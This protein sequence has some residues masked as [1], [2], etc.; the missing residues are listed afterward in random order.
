MIWALAALTVATASA[1]ADGPPLRREDQFKA[2]YVFNF[3]RFVEWPAA[4]SE[5][6]TVC[7]VGA[8][9]VYQALAAGIENKRA[10]ARR[11]AVQRLADTSHAGSCH[12]LY[13]EASMAAAYTPCDGEAMLTISDAKGFAQHGGMIELFSE[14][15]RLRFRIN[16]HNA[17]Q[18]GLRISSDLL[19]LAAAVERGL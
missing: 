17:H 19:K 5:P 14:N 3:I 9:G 11:L 1:R 10:G 13:I 16:V 8:E 7:F 18:T 4:A 15:H 12:A 6:L 2:A